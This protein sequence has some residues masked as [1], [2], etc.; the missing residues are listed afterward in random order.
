[1]IVLLTACV[2][3]EILVYMLNCIYFAKAYKKNCV[4]PLWWVWDMKMKTWKSESFNSYQPFCQNFAWKMY[5]YNNVVNCILDGLSARKGFGKRRTRYCVS[6]GSFQTWRSWSI[7]QLWSGEN[8]ESPRGM[9]YWQHAE[10]AKTCCVLSA[11]ASHI[12][13]NLDFLN[14]LIN[15]NINNQRKSAGRQQM[16]A[17]M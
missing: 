15:E 7:G 13:Q 5:H 10:A 1:M 9:H 4:L 3:F 8:Q 6:S 12:Q 14:L 11:W 16:I 17:T 2:F